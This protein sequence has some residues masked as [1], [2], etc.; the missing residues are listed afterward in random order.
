VNGVLR[1]PNLSGDGALI[2]T[3]AGSA[4]YNK[5]SG[6]TI[7]PIQ[8]RM[9]CL[10]GINPFRPKAWKSAVIPDSANFE[11]RLENVK[12]RP[13]LA[14]ADFNQ[15]YFVN[16]VKAYI[17]KKVSYILLFDKNFDIQEKILQEQ[18]SFCF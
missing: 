14:C 18:F 4:A 1:I 6:G 9:L 15:Y 5:S 3:A 7:L 16:N 11:F 10:T 17:N 13:A 12:E 8:S 2:S